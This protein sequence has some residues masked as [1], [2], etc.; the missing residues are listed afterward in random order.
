MTDSAPS[1]AATVDTTADYQKTIRVKASPDA[2][3]DAVTTVSGITAWWNPVEGSGLT[4]GRLSFFMG[5]PDAL[6]IHVDEARRPVSVSWSVTDC[7][8][9]P[10]WVGTRLTFAITAIDGDTSEL[11][12]R[13]HGLTPELDCVDM[14]TRSWNH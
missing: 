1:S 3:F 13:H 2:L 10:D 5:A 9:L 11:R 7:P 8:V 14:C 6:V 12:F 4:G